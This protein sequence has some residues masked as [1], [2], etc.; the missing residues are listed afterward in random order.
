MPARK[1]PISSNTPQTTSSSRGG[2]KGPL[3]PKTKRA[4]IRRTTAPTPPIMM[5]CDRG[6]DISFKYIRNAPRSAERFWLEADGAGYLVAGVQGHDLH[7]LGG[8][9]GDAHGLQVRADRLAFCGNG[10]EFVFCRYDVSRN[11]GAG[12]RRDLGRL[13]AASAALLHL[14]LGKRRMLAESVLHHHEEAAVLC[15]VFRDEVHR[16]YGVRALEADAGDTR[17]GAAHRPRVGLLEA[18]GLA[19]RCRDDDLVASRGEFYSP[20][21]VSFLE[22]QRNDAAPPDVREVPKRRAFHEAPLRHHGEELACFF[23]AQGRRIRHDRVHRFFRRD[24]EEVMDRLALRDAAA[25]R[26]LIDL[27]LKDAAAA[28]KEEDVVVR[29]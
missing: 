9:A 2:F 26:D 28:R 15:L 14:V 11:D 7:A 3:P 19:L 25:L 16:A 24:L 27:C 21:L 13:H 29:V 5:S 1:A 10:A 18:D 22:V 23:L 4:T 12:F 20:K 17:R 8:A 6:R